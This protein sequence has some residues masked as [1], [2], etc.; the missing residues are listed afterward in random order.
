[1]S[2]LY[3]PFFT[4]L[5]VYTLNNNNNNLIV[6]RVNN[7]YVRINRKHASILN[8]VNIYVKYIIIRLANI[9]QPV[10]APY[11]LTLVYTY[12][13]NM[14]LQ[15]IVYNIIRIKK[16][17]NFLE[18]VNHVRREI[19]FRQFYFSV[20]DDNKYYF[21]IQIFYYWAYY[22]YFIIIYFI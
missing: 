15:T 6:R 2:S 20:Y 11:C 13:N 17:F 22:R 7:N 16:K 4:G 3:T 12:N 21:K 5:V 9:T 10:E 19:K 8:A 14:K 1:M 18:Y